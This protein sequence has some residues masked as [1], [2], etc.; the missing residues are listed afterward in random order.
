MQIYVT[1]LTMTLGSTTEI[2]V[3]EITSSFCVIF[4]ID[5]KPRSP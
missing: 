2:H 1:R 5:I 4:G 3:R